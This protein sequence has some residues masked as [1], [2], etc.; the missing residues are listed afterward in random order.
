MLSIVIPTLD[1][2]AGLERQLQALANAEVAGSAP[3]V[4]IADGG[5][6]DGTVEIALRHGVA[7]VTAEPGRGTQLAEGGRAASGRWLL[8]LHADTV[9][10]EGWPAVVARHMR[11]HEGQSKAAVFRFRLDD[12][13]WQARALEFIV[14]WRCRLFALPYGDQGLLISRE[15]YDAVGGFRDICLMEDV[16]IVSRI[17]R[18]RLTCLNHDAVTSAERYRRDGYVARMARNATCLTLWYLGVS[19]E[20]IAR[21]YR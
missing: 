4:V 3:E 21:L 13:R 2:S 8:F 7:L 15:L 10:A 18:T 17:G 16:D 5:S 9:L 20:R 1:A 12:V 19:P 14:K 11:A 6:G